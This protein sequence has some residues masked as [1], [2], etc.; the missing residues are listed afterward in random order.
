MITSGAVR[1]H[2]ALESLL[3]PIEWVSPHPDNP[4]SGD[5]EAIAVSIEVNGMYRP[6]YAQRSTGWILAGNTTYASCLDL[7]ADLIPVIWLDVDA[8]AA[9]RILLGDNQLARLALVDRGLL[10]PHLNALLAT[11][12]KL[13]G[14]G[15]TE[16]VPPPPV[17]GPGHTVSV[18][19]TGEMMARWF[20]TPGDNDRERLLHLMGLRWSG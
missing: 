13:L 4:S 11:E 16:Y 12:L 3:V 6:V 18:Y 15:F 10:E 5:E 9:L 1:Y 7:G 19:L 8:E 2:P 14:T 17:V 20:D